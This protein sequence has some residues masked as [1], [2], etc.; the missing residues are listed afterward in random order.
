[1]D[2]VSSYIPLRKRGRSYVA[3]CPFHSER[4]PSFTV[5]RERQTYHCFGCGKGGDI[6]SFVMEMENLPFREALEKLAP[7]AGVQLDSGPGRRR[8][9]DVLEEALRFFRDA[10]ASRE[11][12]YAAAYL[13]RRR[14]DRRAL[15]LFEIGWA[16]ASWGALRDHLSSLGFSKGEMLDAGLLV[17]GSKGPYDRFR[18]RVI[19]PLR[20]ET[21]RLVG[22]GG[23]LVDG[24]GAKYVNSPEGPLFEKRKFLYLLNMAKH[25]IRERGRVILVEGYMDAIRCHLTGFSEAVA[26]LGTSLTEEQCGV[27]ARHADRC[28]ICFDSDLA[29]Q[30]ATIRGMYM[31]NRLGVDVEVVRLPRGKDP[32]ELLSQPDG[33][34]DFRRALESTLPLPV[35]HAEVKGGGG[36]LKEMGDLLDQ[37]ATLSP[38]YLKRHMPRVA[39]ALSL[40][41][42]EVE[43]EVAGRRSSKPRVAEPARR[44]ASVPPSRG[45]SREDLWEWGLCSLLWTNPDLRSRQ[46]PEALLPLLMREEARVLVLALLCG[47]RPEELESRW[48]RTGET[49]FLSVLAKGGAFI[50]GLGLDDPLGAVLLNLERNRDLRRYEALKVKIARGDQVTQ[51]DLR[52]FFALAAKM[53]GRG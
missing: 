19:F 43:R 51:E 14:L 2:L 16:P 7:M 18:G 49:V 35:F 32:D 42:H 21:G 39:E 20:N 41:P 33:A 29:G 10:L 37:L 52:E 5:S 53:K 50:D 24:E 40:L 4:T 26:C 36:S 15:E 45:D 1:V 3:L 25:A 38:A 47:E 46:S 22:F 23:R 13:E 48:H 6:F 34:S 8:S 11:G 30:E 31:L 27:I 9:R 28:L 12:A 44:E 17:E